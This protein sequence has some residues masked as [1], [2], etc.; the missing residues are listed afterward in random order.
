[1]KNFNYFNELVSAAQRQRGDKGISQFMREEP[2]IMENTAWRIIAERH[3]GSPSHDFGN[4]ADERI[5]HVNTHKAGYTDSW[6]EPFYNTVYL[7]A[8]DTAQPIG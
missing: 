6:G 2:I 7:Q 4:I 5:T 3:P 1:M 8:I